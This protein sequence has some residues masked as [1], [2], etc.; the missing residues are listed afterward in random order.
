M[1][2]QVFLDTNVF[3]YAF[4]YPGSNSAKIISM[5]N[6]GDLEAFITPQVLEEAV[7]YFRN[8]HN[9]ELANEF[10]YYLLEVCNIVYEPEIDEEMQ[11]NKG[12]VKSADLQQIAAAKHLQLKLISYDDDFKNFEECAVPQEFIK[13]LGKKHSSTKF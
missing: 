8:L 9:K 2:K 1:A 11:K 5:V 13:S 12:K 3:I 10:R 7:R 6:E 4:E